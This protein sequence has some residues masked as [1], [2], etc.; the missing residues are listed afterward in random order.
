MYTVGKIDVEKYRVVSP[1]I[2]TDEVII[3]EERI[4]HIQERHPGE[5]ERYAGYLR[6]V[7]EHP[8]YIIA[9]ERPTTAVVLKELEAQ[10]D[11]LRLAL[12]L[13]T[14]ADHPDHKNSVLT[15]MRI[16]EKEWLRLLRNKKILYKEG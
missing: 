5:L 9:D 10:G 13:A 14:A 2:R 1:D 11:H 15:F 3:T 4:R 7:V 16:R 6:D 8:A 12:R